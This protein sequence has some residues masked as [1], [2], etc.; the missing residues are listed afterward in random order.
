MKCCTLMFAAVV[1]VCCNAWSANSTVQC[2]ELVKLSGK[3]YVAAIDCR[4]NGNSSDFAKGAHTIAA[5]FSIT[6]SNFTGR[7]FTLSNAAEQL[8]ASG[9]NVAVFIA[10]DPTL[11]FALSAPEEK[12]AMLNAARALADSPDEAK[13]RR[14]LSL[15][16]VRQCCRALGSDETK[17]TDTCLHSILSLHDLDAITSFDITM[18]PEMGIPE[19]MTLRGIEKIEYGTYEEACMMG[20]ASKPTNAVQKAIW[21]KVHALPTEPIKIKPEAKKV[22]E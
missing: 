21:E 14:R 3:G 9:G 10:D 15:L 18:G 13:R 12:W 20:V 8:R 7:A 19:T 17:G 4:Q 16:F 2:E 5:L 22:R 6:V 1:A 11:P